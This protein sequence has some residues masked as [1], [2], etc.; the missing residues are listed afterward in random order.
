VINTNLTLILHRFKVMADCM[1]NF[2]WR[3]RSLHFNVLAGGDPLRI[4]PQWYT[5]TFH[6]Q[7]IS[8]Y[9]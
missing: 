6:S 7:N 3:Q 4:S 9:L 8:V 1:S 5:A 2:P